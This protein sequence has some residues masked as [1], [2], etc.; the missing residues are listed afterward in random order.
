MCKTYGIQMIDL[1]LWRTFKGG[2]KYRPVSSPLIHN[3]HLIFDKD[4]DET[5]RRCWKWGTSNPKS[6]RSLT[7]AELWHPKW[8]KHKPRVSRSQPQQA[9]M[10]IDGVKLKW[11]SDISSTAY[12]VYNTALYI[13]CKLLLY[14]PTALLNRRRDTCIDFISNLFKIN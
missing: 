9:S 14:S 11:C 4:H 6:T 1:P 7:G 3:I 2:G 12:P 5:S 10:Q 13:K 8:Q